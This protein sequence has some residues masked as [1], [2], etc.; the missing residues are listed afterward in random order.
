MQCNNIKPLVASKVHLLPLLS[1]GYNALM[2]INVLKNVVNS[3][4]SIRK[5]SL[6]IYVCYTYQL[7]KLLQVTYKL[8]FR[9]PCL[10]NDI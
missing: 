5:Y 8:Y 9:K 4:G 1:R 10:I 3:P 7:S 6:G 2:C